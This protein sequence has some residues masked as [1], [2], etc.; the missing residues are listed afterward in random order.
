MSKQ[1]N[2]SQNPYGFGLE[3]LAG[4]LALQ[5]NVG[6]MP[7]NTVPLP[8]MQQQGSNP[9]EQ[10]WWEQRYAPVPASAMNHLSEDWHQRARMNSSTPRAFLN[11]GQL[12]LTRDPATN[13]YLQNGQPIDQQEWYRLYNDAIQRGH[14][15]ATFGQQVANGPRTGAV[16]DAYAAR[17]QQPQPM[18][19]RP[20]LGSY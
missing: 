13:S 20:G 6:G 8:Q 17:V 10:A 11:I 12:G 1:A 2:G 9:Q 4:K 3:R 18:N 14:D 5:R 19:R 7:T 15:P 16:A